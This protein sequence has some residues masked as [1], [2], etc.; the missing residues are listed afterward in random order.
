M[1][2]GGGVQFGA[3]DSRESGAFLQGRGDLSSIRAEKQGRFHGKRDAGRLGC[4]AARSSLLFIAGDRCTGKYPD[5]DE[6]CMKEPGDL[7]RDYPS[8]S[9]LPANA[10]CSCDEERIHVLKRSIFL[11]NLK[12]AVKRKNLACLV[13]FSTRSRILPV[14]S[15]RP[16]SFPRRDLFF[17]MRKT[18]VTGHF[19]GV[20]HIVPHQARGKPRPGGRGPV[21][22]PLIPYV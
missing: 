3:Q 15:G 8:C 7:P 20:L 21:F 17:R 14:L 16:H 4:G 2:V 18:N 10:A 5:R 9:L 22:H 6:H 19:H 1:D 11:I 12:I 13:V